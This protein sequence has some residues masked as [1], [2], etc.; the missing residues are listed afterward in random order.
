MVKSKSIYKKQTAIRLLRE[1]LDVQLCRCEV[2]NGP[3]TRELQFEDGPLFCDEHGGEGQ[4][5]D[6]N[7][8]YCVVNANWVRDAVAILKEYDKK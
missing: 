7:K 8:P 2:C 3:A 1:V 5:K 4:F 6:L